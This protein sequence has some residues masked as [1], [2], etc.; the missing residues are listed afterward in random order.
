MGAACGTPFAETAKG[1]PLST[2]F[3]ALVSRVLITQD[4]SRC[5]G[6]RCCALAE[7]EREHAATKE[8]LD[9]EQ[10]AHTETTE[11]VAAAEV[12]QA[13]AT[14]EHEVAAAAHELGSHAQSSE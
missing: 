3:G 4:T 10:A 5:A 7:A 13:A 6:S 8:A 14:G 9:A 1:V 2:M 12:A 11:A